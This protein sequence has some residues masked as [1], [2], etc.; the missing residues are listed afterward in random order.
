MEAKN[1]NI[2]I[3]YT[4]WIFKWL[5]IFVVIIIVILGIVYW[6]G[7][8]YLEQEIDVFALNCKR[9]FLANNIEFDKDTSHFY[10]IRKKRGEEELFGIYRGAYHSQGFSK[11]SDY[12]NLHLLARFF[13][14]DDDSY[15]F[16]DQDFDSAFVILNRKNL[17]LRVELRD[18]ET[19]EKTV[20]IRSK[21]SIISNDAF[22]KEVEKIT[23]EKQ[24]ELKI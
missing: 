6:Y 10:L 15:V 9:N 2:L 17:E 16:L 7:E 3:G 11:N 4:K 22:Y 19:Q 21:C 18:K 20:I 14:F 8:E 1:K 24:K 12:R 23:K 5:V 13:G